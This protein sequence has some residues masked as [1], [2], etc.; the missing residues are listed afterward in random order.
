M[1]TL[2]DFASNIT[3]AVISNISINALGRT[4][5]EES[6]LGGNFLVSKDSLQRSILPIVQSAETQVKEISLN[7][8][9]KYINDRRLATLSTNELHAPEIAA[10]GHFLSD[11]EKEMN[12]YLNNP[13][14]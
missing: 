8:V 13:I 5:L 12:L 14:I 4:Q 11:L 10:I 2:P 6:K 3:Q 9:K 7:W 1:N